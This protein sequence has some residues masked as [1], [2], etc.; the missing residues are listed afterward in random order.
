MASCVGPIE[1]PAIG[2]STKRTR[3]KVRLTVTGV[4]FVGV[5][6]LAVL[7]TINRKFVSNISLIISVESTEQLFGERLLQLPEV[8][9]SVVVLKFAPLSVTKHSSV[10]V[11]TLLIIRV[12]MQLMIL[13]VGKCLLVYKLTAIVGPK[14]LLETR[15]IVKVTA[16]MAR[17]NVNVMLVK[18]T[19]NL[20]KF[21]VS[22]VSL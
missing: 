10:V 1:A 3:A 9:L 13:P 5:N 7:R 4:K 18:L 17:L 11:I 22:I 6:P 15:L 8:K 12:T 20:G 19:F 21:V 14:R 16:R 2:T